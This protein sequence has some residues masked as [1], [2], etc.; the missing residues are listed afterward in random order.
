MRRVRALMPYLWLVLVWVPVAYGVAY[1][2]EGV[3]R[4]VI[5]AGSFRFERPWAALLFL[6]VPL[7]FA[8]HHGQRYTRPRLQF[9]H[10]RTLKRVAP[11][12]KLWLVGLPPALRSA[13]VAL[14]VFG[15]MGPQSIH[16]R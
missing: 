8:A 16:A 2:I 6:A 12:K 15:M 4:V 3:Y 11:G 1:G 14:I 13:A 5:E 9:S 10:V 7:I